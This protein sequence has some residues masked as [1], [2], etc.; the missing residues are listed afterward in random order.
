MNF[1]WYLDPITDSLSPV[2]FTGFSGKV[3][4][5]CVA[6]RPAPAPVTPVRL[7]LY[8]APGVK[9]F[10][11]CFVADADMLK[12]SDQ[13]RWKQMNRAGTTSASFIFYITSYKK[14]VTNNNRKNYFCTFL[15]ILWTD[16]LAAQVVVCKEASLV[17][18]WNRFPGQGSRVLCFSNNSEVPRFFVWH[19]TTQWNSCIFYSGH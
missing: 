17:L 9:P 2:P 18:V 12:H 14:K 10:R 15:P 19:W 4:M 3:V 11:W 5:V 8:L 7:M 16:F 6:E 1:K 13:M